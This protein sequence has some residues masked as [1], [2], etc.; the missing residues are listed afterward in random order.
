MTSSKPLMKTLILSSNSSVSRL[1]WRNVFGF[2]WTSPTKHPWFDLPLRIGKHGTT[3]GRI[4]RVFLLKHS[5][6][7]ELI[8]HTLFIIMDDSA[9]L[10]SPS[11]AYW[12]DSCWLLSRDLS[13][14][15]S[16]S[17]LCWFT[18]IWEI[19][20]RILCALSYCFLAWSVPAGQLM[21][22]IMAKRFGYSCYYP[23]YTSSWS[24]RGV[25]YSILHALPRKSS[26]SLW[27]V[28]LKVSS[29]KELFCNL[30]TNWFDE[31]G[32]RTGSAW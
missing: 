9:N 27:R 17:L 11:N 12:R 18:N 20:G 28:S 24:P 22:G 19:V 30:C 26:G 6:T 14:N 2:C 13:G 10:V 29:V 15:R 32:S 25:P 5:K 3:Q 4:L 16:C 8:A 1:P 7:P 23:L 31:R 21:Y